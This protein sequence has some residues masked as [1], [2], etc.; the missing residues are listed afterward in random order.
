MVGG[1]ALL[2]LLLIKI[3]G[4]MKLNL[5]FHKAKST[6]FLVFRPEV[7]WFVCGDDTRLAHD[8]FRKRG[9]I[10]C[11]QC[12]TGAIAEIGSVKCI[13]CVEGKIPDIPKRHC[14]DC[15][16]SKFSTYGAAV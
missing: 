16:A 15:D 11:D 7:P 1:L 13:Q 2:L 8:G 10:V 4:S 9:S 3:T 6:L 5:R 14:T 12:I